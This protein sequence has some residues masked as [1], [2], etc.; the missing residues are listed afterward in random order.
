MID[1]DKIT[2]DPNYDQE[3]YPFFYDGFRAEQSKAIFLALDKLAE[4]CSP[5]QIVEIGT[6]NGGFT[7]ILDDHPISEKALIYTFDINPDVIKPL[8][9]KVSII[10]GDC[11]KERN[12][13]KEIIQRKGTSLVFCDGGNKNTEINKFSQYLKS[14]DI[15]FG[16]DYAPTKEIWEKEYLGKIWDWF[17]CWDSGV[18]DAVR[19]LNLEPYLKEYFDK[20]VWNC[21]RKP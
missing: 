3:Y 11:F 14:G 2:K 5:L 16:H 6:R 9:Q 7:K 12:V 1:L 15:I 10:Q 18:E 8:S 13:I 4:N 17:E 20:A 19:N 21:L